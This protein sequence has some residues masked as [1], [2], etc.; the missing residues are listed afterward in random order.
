[1]TKISEKI[2][3]IALLTI[4]L[5]NTC[6]NTIYAAVEIE[7]SKFFLQK[8]GEAEHHLK[9]YRE[10]DNEYRYLKCSIVGYYDKNGNFNRSRR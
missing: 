8:I 9:Y 10:D 7:T 4:M 2:L 6:A 1:M 5:L 3:V